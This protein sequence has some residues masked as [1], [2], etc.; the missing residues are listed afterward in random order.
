MSF[1]I[2]A[3]QTRAVTILN[4]IMSETVILA[5][6]NAP[7]PSGAYM[8]IQV[9]NTNQRGEPQETQINNTTQNVIQWDELILQ[10][11]AVGADS[12]A[13]AYKAR[14]AFG[15]RSVVDS[16]AGVYAGVGEIMQ[17]QNV[18]TLFSNGW[19]D[20]SVFDVRFNVV[21]ETAETST[22]IATAQVTGKIDERDI[23]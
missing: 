11:K 21:T 1:T 23:I 18:P 5:N 16:F 17:I 15:L 12:M 2:S 3:F 8:V 13:R 7:R 6:Q 4:T 20:Q 9:L 19:Q 22:T 10:V 14:T